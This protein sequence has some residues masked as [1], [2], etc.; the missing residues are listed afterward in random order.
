MAAALAD[1]GAS[2]VSE[3]TL[4]SAHGSW[5][6]DAVVGVETLASLRR[7]AVEF[8][9]ALI[10]ERAPI[11][12]KRAA[13]VWGDSRADFALMQR[14]KAQFDPAGTLNPGRFLGGI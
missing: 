3:P 2:V 10:L 9:G 13:N 7:Q 1:A 12:L 14:L 6:E 4:G 5:T 8:G 11:E